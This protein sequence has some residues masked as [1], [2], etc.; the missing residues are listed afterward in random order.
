[1]TDARHA[2]SLQQADAAANQ[3]F[4]VCASFA[5]EQGLCSSCLI[6][7]A[8]LRACYWAAR[9]QATDEEDLKRLAQLIGA[10]LLEGFKDGYGAEEDEDEALDFDAD[11]ALVAYAGETRH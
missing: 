1:M 5:E 2:I 11:P 9:Q 3:F 6:A 10:E 8:T 7:Q 4:E